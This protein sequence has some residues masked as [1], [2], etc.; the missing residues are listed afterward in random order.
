MKK[1][2]FKKLFDY[3]KLLYHFNKENIEQQGDEVLEDIASWIVNYASFE[4]AEFDIDDDANAFEMILAWLCDIQKGLDK[5]YI[6]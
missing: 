4:T 5:T 3:T 2:E 6:W 1:E